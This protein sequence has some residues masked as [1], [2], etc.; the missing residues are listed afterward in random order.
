M[1]C[2]TTIVTWPLLAHGAILRA[3][4]MEP[5]W[6]EVMACANQV[7]SLSTETQRL[8]RENQVVDAKCGEAKRYYQS[9][10]ELVDKA[11]KVYESRADFRLSDEQ[12]TKQY[13]DRYTNTMCMK[14]YDA[15]FTKDPDTRL[16]VLKICIGR[17]SLAPGSL[18]DGSLGRAINQACPQ[19]QTIKQMQDRV[20]MLR[21]AKADKVAQ[22]NKDTKELKAQLE[23]KRA[24]E[25]ALQDKHY[26]H[27][28]NKQELRKQIAKSVERKFCAVIQP[29]YKL[30][31]EEIQTFWHKNC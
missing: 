26:E 10:A 1:R 20:N 28:D 29:N 25:D 2:F 30:N 27:H 22:C 17:V 21:S 7:T 8:L 5:S 4:S 13:T 19:A 12:R 23:Q 16:E 6:K 11:I 15:F 9:Q 14:S 31:E 3:S 24:K 18:L